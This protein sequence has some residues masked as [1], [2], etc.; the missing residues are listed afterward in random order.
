MLGPRCDYDTETLYIVEIGRVWVAG[1]P[2]RT[3][4]ALILVSKGASPANSYSSLRQPNLAIKCSGYA[5]SIDLCMSWTR[6]THSGAEH[7]SS[8]V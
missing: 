6:L 3:L 8:F 7:F 2:L 4:F 5:M 1:K